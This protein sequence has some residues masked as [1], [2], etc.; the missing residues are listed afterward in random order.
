MRSKIHM[1][2]EFTISPLTKERVKAILDLSDWNFSSLAMMYNRQSFLN[3]STSSLSPLKMVGSAILGPD[4]PPKGRLCLAVVVVPS[5]ELPSSLPLVL[6]SPRS[7]PKS[8]STSAS[9]GGALLF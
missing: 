9:D 3:D 8:P 2:H 4:P 1:A 7:F 5:W 6:P